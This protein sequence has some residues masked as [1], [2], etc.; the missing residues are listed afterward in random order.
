MISQFENCDDLPLFAVATQKEL[1]IQRSELQRSREDRKALADK[2][3]SYKAS[4]IIK[5]LESGPV[6][7]RQLEGM[8]FDGSRLHRAQAVICTMRNKGHIIETQRVNGVECYIY[9]GFEPRLDSKPF[10]NLYYTTK[11]WRTKSRL[12][13]EMDAFICRQCGSCENLETHHWRYNLF[14]ESE[15]HDLITLCKRCHEMIHEAVSGSSIHFPLTITEDEA[16]RIE[17][18]Q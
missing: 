3:Y 16:K 18:D 11:H 4:C 12:R 9:K 15:I 13:K 5:A 14:N 6:G 2:Q 8:E 1:K 7:C 10:K 17:D